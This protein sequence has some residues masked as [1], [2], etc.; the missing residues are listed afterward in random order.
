L[1]VELDHPGHRA[2]WDP[3][4]DAMFQTPEALVHDNG[5]EAVDVIAHRH[6]VLAVR[7]A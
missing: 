4:I 1:G 7:A 6:K 3:L 2:Y 5:S